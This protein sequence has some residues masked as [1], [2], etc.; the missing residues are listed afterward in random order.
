MEVVETIALITINATVVFQLLSFLIFL[1][2]IHRIMIRPLD[3][4][5]QERQ[6]FLL[7][8][9]EE[10][11]EAGEEYDQIREEIRSREQEARDT[12][13]K[14]RNDI[15]AAGQQTATEMI[16]RTREEIKAMKSAVQ[17]ETAAKLETARVEA[18][19]EAVVVAERMIAL[20]L[21][22]KVEV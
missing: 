4:V 17:A 5:M 19:N 8:L 14:I 6:F 10:I 12:A 11:A 16:A 3:R 20:L 18:K 1:F 2:I 22:R 7:R 21:D 13:Q 9:N 15:E